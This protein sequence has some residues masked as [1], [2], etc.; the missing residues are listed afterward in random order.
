M[1][2]ARWIGRLAFVWLLGLGAAVAQSTTLRIATHADLKILDPVWTTAAI[3][4]NHG[5]AIYDTLFG[6]DAHGEIRPQ[7]V[8]SYR[9]SD[10]ARTWTFTLRE[11]LE[12]HDGQP[13]T[14][15]DVVQSIRRWG[16]RDV[17]GQVMMAALGELGPLDEKTFTMRFDRP[18]RMVLEALAKPSASALFIMPRAVAAT[19][20][21]QRITSTVG[22]GP[23]I[24][25]ADEY[26]PGERVVYVRN[27]RYRPRPEPPDGTAGGKVVR[28]DR[29]EWVSLRDPQTQANALINGEIDLLEWVPADQ[30]DTLRRQSGIELYSGDAVGSFALHLNRR[31]PP[32]DDARIARAALLSINQDALLKAQ[33]HSSEL[34][35]ANPSIFPRGSPYFSAEASEFTGAPQFDKARALLKEAGYAGQ[36]I[37]F[38]DPSNFSMVN[39]L[40][41]VMAALLRHVGFVVDLQPMDW[42]TL[43]ARRTVKK[44]ATQG[45]WNAFVTG[46]LMAD[47]LN[48]LFFPPLSGRGEDGWYGWNDDEELEVLKTRFVEAGD[49]AQRKTIA[50]RMQRRAFEDGAFAPLGE[51]KLLSA[52][53]RGRLSGLIT[54]PV[55][56]L[57]GVEKH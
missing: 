15:A 49:A 30:Y 13:V 1:Q 32:F 53:R 27:P 5:Y 8:E 39:R 46:W 18:F 41:Q 25:K 44:P 6:L 50:A 36:P 45:G 11:G 22:S 34:Y 7:M 4:R 21:D 33:L 48:P 12:F 37:V 52:F 38:L 3:T 56:V 55:N 17:L 57:W 42:S 47:N 14:S 16:Q 40:P 29:M 10:D 2:V 19:P 35:R 20:A 24:F 23:Y 26:R 51:F 31:V 28:I 9:V 54:A 43:L